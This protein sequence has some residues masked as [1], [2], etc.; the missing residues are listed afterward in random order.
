MR[1]KDAGVKTVQLLMLHRRESPEHRGR[2]QSPFN[3]IFLFFVSVL[4]LCPLC[5]PWLVVRLN[6]FQGGGAGLDFADHCGAAE[7]FAAKH[8]EH[9]LYRF[10]RAGHKK[11]TAGLRIG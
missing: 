9:P 11:P 6:D 1:R 5:S 7:A 2:E 10:R 8:V 3:P 4:P